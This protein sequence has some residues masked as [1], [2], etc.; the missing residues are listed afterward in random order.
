M[1][2]IKVGIFGTGFGS[3]VSIPAVKSVKDFKLIGIYGRNKKKLNNISKKHQTS[4]FSKSNELFNKIEFAI[5]AMPPF[6]QYLFVKKAILSNINVL[7]EKPFT[8]NVK[9]AKKLFDLSKKKTNLFFGISY[10]MRFQ[11]LRE[12]IKLLIDKNKLGNILSV[13]LSYD[14][15]SSLYNFNNKSWKNNTKFGGGVL[16]AM[17]SHQLDLLQ[18]LFGDITR[19]SGIKSNYKKNKFNKTDDTFCGYIKFKNGLVCSIFLTST[20]IGWKTSNMEIY[21]DKA[22]LHLEGERKLYLIKKTNFKN[23]ENSKKIQIKFKENFFKK[24]WIDNSIWRSSYLRMLI[25]ISNKMVR[26]KKYKGAN[27]KDGVKIRKL[28]DTVC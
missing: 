18:W 24:K 3:L 8:V 26:K 10:Q 11:P 14:Y 22:S 28:L 4:V 9:E 2:K 16:N 1:S 17:G 25:Q 15:S 27:F 19:I 6:L 7:C 13:R 21:G 20:G 12:K 5:I 23:Q